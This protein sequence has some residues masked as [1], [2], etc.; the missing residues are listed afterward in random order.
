VSERWV[1]LDVADVD[2]NPFAQFQRWFDEARGEM[3][4]R[5][6]IALVTASLEG[7]PSARMVLLRFHDGTSFGW[8]SNYDSRKGHELEENP[9]AALLWY[10]EPLGRQIRIEGSVQRMTPAESDAYFDGRPRGSQIGAHASHQSQPLASRS[11]LEQRVAVVDEQFQGREVPRPENWG[12]FRLTP[13]RFEFWQHR[14][15]RLHDRVVYLP[16]GPLWR[17]ERQSP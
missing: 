16:D 1:P 4:E 14:D 17:R 7:A 10:C 5:E 12:G 8:Y 6:A 3:P 13:D 15:D 11:E 9:R 2:P